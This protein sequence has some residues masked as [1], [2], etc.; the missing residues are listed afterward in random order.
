VTD[1]F[2][3]AVSATY[4]KTQEKFSE[5]NSWLVENILPVGQ[6]GLVVA[7][8]KSFKSSMTLNMAIA[9]S[10]GKEFAG[11]KTKK[12]NVLIIDQEDTD[13][14]LHQRLNGYSDDEELEGL[15]FLTGGMF[16]LDNDDHM[17][18]LYMF[19]K[20]NDIKLVILDNLKDL[21]SS[22]DTLNDMS[23]MNNVLNKITR[24]KLILNDVTFILVAHARKSVADDSLDNKEFRVRSTHA[25]GSSAIG[26]WFEFCL[27]LSPKLG[28]HSRYSVMSV[29]ARNFAFNKE[30]YFGYVADKFLMIDPTKKEPEPD[31]ELVEEVKKETPIEATEESAKAFLELAK[32]EGKVEEID[33]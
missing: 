14:V 7:P 9:V 27:T 31:T 6:A 3:R 18:R 12:G 32:E 11:Y 15:H 4:L 20:E 1:I 23:R 30:L 5:E 25:L 13:F 16:R 10:Q 24:L 28:K 19:I 21:L 29:E 2:K 8:S 26:S 22:E 33:N 17:N